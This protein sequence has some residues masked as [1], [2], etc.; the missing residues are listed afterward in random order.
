VIPERRAGSC[1]GA[2]L[3]EDPDETWAS[4]QLKPK[5]VDYLGRW[6]GS[7]WVERVNPFTDTEG[8][9]WQWGGCGC[10]MGN[11]LLFGDERVIGRIRKA[12]R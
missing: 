3:T 9:L 5:I 1:N 8:L 10:R 6:R 11:F 4:F 2:F 7:V 12:F